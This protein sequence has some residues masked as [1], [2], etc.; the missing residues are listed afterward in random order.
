MF[1]SNRGSD[2]IT[3]FVVS[4][5]GRLEIRD[6]CTSGGQGPRDFAVFD[7]LIISANQYTDNLAVL[8]YSGDTGKMRLLSECEAVA[9]PVMILAL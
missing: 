4:E 1:V 9:K 7:N 8:E 6:F 3:S 5:D 2:S